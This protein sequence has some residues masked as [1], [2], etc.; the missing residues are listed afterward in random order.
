MNE[1]RHQNKVAGLSI[2]LPLWMRFSPSTKNVM[3]QT[4]IL[5]PIV[6]ELGYQW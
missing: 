6:I 2:F 5:V 3:I 1:S 4:L